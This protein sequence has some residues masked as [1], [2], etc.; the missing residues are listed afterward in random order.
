MTFV[1]IHYLIQFKDISKIR[2]QGGKQFTSSRMKFPN[3]IPSLY[4]DVS[5]ENHVM[6]HLSFEDKLQSIVTVIKVR[7]PAQ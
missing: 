4:N 6:V 7:I 2:G 1:I 3:D 5:L